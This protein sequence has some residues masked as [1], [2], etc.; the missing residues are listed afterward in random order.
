M[1]NAA[2]SFHGENSFQARVHKCR[3][4]HGIHGGRVSGLIIWHIDTSDDKEREI[5][6]AHYDRGWIIKPK[7]PY[8]REV[9][10]D[11]LFFTG[12]CPAR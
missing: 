2:L 6:I 1:L 3:S 4:K 11:A 9:F 7:A 10:Q 12:I 8:A 5:V